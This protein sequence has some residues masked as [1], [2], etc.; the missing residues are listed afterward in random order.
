[1]SAARSPRVVLACDYHLRYC[2]RLAGGLSRAGA[3]VTLLTRDHD[4]EFGGVPGAALEFV[5]PAIGP[6]VA[7]KRIPSRVRSFAGWR[8]LP[9]LRRALRRG[10]PGFVHVQ[11]SV[12]NDPRLVLAA[13]LRPG[14]FA[15]TL[16]DPV[17]HPGDSGSRLAM[18]SDRALVK[19]AGLIFVHGEAL[20]DE[21]IEVSEPRAPLVVVPH[22]IAVGDAAPLPRSPSA[23]FFGRISHY[24][25]LDILLDA[26]GEVWRTLPEATLTVAGAG[27]VEPHPALED[28]RVT[29][30]R[31][32]VPDAEI[33]ALFES[34]TAV[35]LPYR[36]ASQSGVGSLAKA[37]ARPLIVTGVGGLPELVADGSGLVIEPESP[38]ALAEALTSLL[39]DR[40]LAERLGSSGAASAARE[41][42]WD[43]VAERTLAAYREHLTP[44]RL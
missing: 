27:E 25:G 30:R 38:A 29:V 16:H 4:G 8:R 10:A 36:Q 23:L 28:S 33:G 6:D 13:G 14:R 24:K 39:G 43:V 19:T 15:L 18:L 3:D 34:A 2:S 5:G 12:G 11:E 9:A 1:M 20:R 31:G 7:L 41:S 37:H 17:I 44:R 22:G 26:M 35:A 32:H 42:S 21:L 40:A